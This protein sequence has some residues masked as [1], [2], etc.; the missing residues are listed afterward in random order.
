LAISAARVAVAAARWL[1]VTT[2]RYAPFTWALGRGVL[3]AQLWTFAWVVF[4]VLIVS[5]P[6]AWRVGRTALECVAVSCIV[7]VVACWFAMRTAGMRQ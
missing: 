6:G 1:S 5:V 2:V 7:I 3:L 4:F